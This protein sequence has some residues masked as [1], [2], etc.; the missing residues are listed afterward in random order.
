MFQETILLTP[1]KWSPETLAI[2]WKL[3]SSEKTLG[4]VGLL[5]FLKV[6]ISTL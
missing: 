1:V 3:S 6:S 5:K 2:Y 4:E